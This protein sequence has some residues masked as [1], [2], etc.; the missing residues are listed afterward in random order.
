MKTR[1]LGPFT[2]SAIGLGCMPLSM[3]TDRSPLSQD[4]A[5]AVVGAA[6]EAGVTF[7]DTADIYA[8]SA[9]QMGHNER[10]LAE[11]LRVHGS[12]DVVVATKAGIT[13]DGDSWGRDGSPEYLRAAC[14]KALANLGVDVIDLFQYH[15]PDREITYRAAMEVFAA[16]RDEGKVRA[17]GVS[18]ANVEELRIAADV[19]GEGGLASV[20]NE[21]SPRFRCSR[22]E[23][24][25][26]ARNGAAFLP[27]SPLGG[28]GGDAKLIQDRYPAFAEVADEL[29]ASVQQVALAWELKTA[30]VVI[31]IPGA[32]RPESIANSAE[33]VA[34]E[35]SDE[36]YQ[37]LENC[38]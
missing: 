22:P 12:P 16:L 13:R 2:V 37:R 28:T 15:R 30:D 26:C 1:T 34:I 3:G 23:L 14:D 19:L 31:P 4:D 38:R 32:S 20:Q 18:N 17:V 25:W 21:Y 7:F 29:G 8:P 24:D 35:L 6:L 36:Q 27:W 33:A 9:D 11:A 5:N 10:L